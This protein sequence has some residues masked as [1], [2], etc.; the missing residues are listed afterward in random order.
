[1]SLL[2]T[3][4]L[5][6]PIRVAWTNRP[7]KIVHGRVGRRHSGRLYVT[8]FTGFEKC[9]R[10]ITRTPSSSRPCVCLFRSKLFVPNDCRFTNKIFFTLR[11]KNVLLR[12]GP[13]IT[14]PGAFVY[15]PLTVHVRQ[16][17]FDKVR[18][19]VMNKNARYRATATTRIS[20][21]FSRGVLQNDTAG[22][23]KV[24]EFVD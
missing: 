4:F 24:R 17:I 20:T 15:R 2:Y 23:Q 1:M 22:Y 18:W 7:P 16:T 13:S 19:F 5:P 21:S 10:E 11:K 14:S 8:R 6:R 3:L 9:S 12:D